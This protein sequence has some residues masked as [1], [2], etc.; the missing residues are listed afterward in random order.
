MSNRNETGQPF[1]V[2]VGFRDSHAPW[3]APQRMQDLYNDADIAP[4]SDKVLDPSIPLIAWSKC[5][6]TRLENGTNFP[7]GYNFSIPDWVA[8][9]QRRHYYAAV[10]YVDEHVGELLNLLRTAG[11]YDDTIVVFH[12]DH[13]YL[14][15]EHGYWEKKSNFDLAVRVPMMIKV[16][17][18]APG[19]TES[20]TEL[21]D[22]FPTLASLADLPAPQGVDGQD[23]SALFDHPGQPLKEAAYHQY[24]AC[25]TTSINHTREECNNA[26]PADFEFMAYSVRVDTWRYTVWLPWDGK[27]RVANWNVTGGEELFS[28][29][30]DDGTDFDSFENVNVVAQQPQLALQLRTQ[31]RDFF[32]TH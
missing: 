14:L 31:L 21:I 3:A 19:R 28:H 23:V 11:H 12:T 17:G 16:P 32:A 6:A 22:V 24:P 29:E 9:D 13:G 4:A 5:L 26:P 2:S 10:S 30:G 1:Y 7:F 25:K 15:G 18:K 20:L 27:T 8:R